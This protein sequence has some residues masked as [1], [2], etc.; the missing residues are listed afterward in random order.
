M[1][2]LKAGRPTDAERTFREDLAYWSKNGWSLRGL[3]RSLREQ[4]KAAEAKVAEKR[5]KAAWGDMAPVQDSMSRLLSR[6]SRARVA[7][8]PASDSS[9]YLIDT[10]CK[11]APDTI[12][13]P[14]PASSSACHSY[15]RA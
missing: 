15:R 5:F 7:L 14:A 11:P 2:Y 6:L 4:K 13:T 1:L 12:P 8:T 10:V 9:A 3:A